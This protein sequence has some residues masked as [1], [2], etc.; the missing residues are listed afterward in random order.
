MGEDGGGR[1]GPPQTNS[2][3]VTKVQLASAFSPKQTRAVKVTLSS[4][5]GG[6]VSPL[7]AAC[8]SD[9]SSSSAPPEN[10]PEKTPARDIQIFRVN[11][12]T[13]G[14]KTTGRCFCR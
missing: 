11:H 6:F 10:P 12:E 2:L 9:P 8:G 7:T 1:T 3:Q 14:G 4:Q 5:S 13:G